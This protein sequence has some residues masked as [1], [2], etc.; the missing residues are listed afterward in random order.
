M[1]TRIKNQAKSH[2]AQMWTYKFEPQVDLPPV[3]DILE[4]YWQIPSLAATMYFT[5]IS[6]R[7]FMADANSISESCLNYQFEA[8]S[9]RRSS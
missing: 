2:K 5:G 9:S 7:R 8:V 4:E 1:M 3:G 6:N